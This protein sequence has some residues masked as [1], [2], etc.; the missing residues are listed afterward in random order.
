MH[1]YRSILLRLFGAKIGKHVHI[2]PNVKIWAPWNL[3]VDDYTGV[4]DGVTLYNMDKIVIGSYCVISQGAHLCGGSHDYNSNNFQL[5]ARPIIIKNRA[6]I[7]AESFLFLGVTIEEGVVVG[8]RS[9]VKKDCS[10][11]WGVY[12]GNPCA[13][14]GERKSFGDIS[15]TQQY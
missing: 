10:I 1:E 15:E 13:K 2:Y 9:V 3:H 11:P 4:A 12:A 5:F 6:W 14:V 7:C 8:A